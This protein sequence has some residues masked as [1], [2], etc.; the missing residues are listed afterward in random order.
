MMSDYDAILES[1]RFAEECADKTGFPAQASGLGIAR[2]IVKRYQLAD[3]VCSKCGAS[4]ADH[5]WTANQQV[6]GTMRR[7]IFTCADCKETK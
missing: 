4:G 1:L 3:A 5:T 7:T 2:D 6:R